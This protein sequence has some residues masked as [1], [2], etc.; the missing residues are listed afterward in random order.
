MRMQRTRRLASLGRSL[1]SLGSPLMRKP[2]GGRINSWVLAAAGLIA[3]ASVASFLSC[4]STAPQHVRSKAEI[5][6]SA[7]SPSAGADLSKSSVL[8]ATVAY[9]ISGFGP[10]ADRYYLTTQ[11]EKVGGGSFNHY[12]RF[13]EE[14]VISADQGSVHVTYPLA[15]VWDDQRLK[16]PITVWFYVI[17]RT[18]AHD[19][20]VIGKAGPFEYGLK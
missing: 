18:S 11:F 12:R 9:R 3:L 2:L 5:T 17:E 7:I 14:A 20:D 6:V 19:S 10:D 4:A 1:R 8:D 15:H 16:K 13:S